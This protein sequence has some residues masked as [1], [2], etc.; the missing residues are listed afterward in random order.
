[1][2]AVCM[3]DMCPDGVYFRVDGACHVTRDGVVLCTRPVAT[4]D[5]GGEGVIVPVE[6]IPDAVWWLLVYADG[7]GTLG[8]DCRNIVLRSSLLPEVVVVDELPELWCPECGK[9]IVD[10]GVWAGGRLSV[11]HSDETQHKRRPSDF[12]TR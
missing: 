11:L 6:E 8:D 4:P 1:M 7:T 2:I 12:L 10:V 5:S 9:E 3:S